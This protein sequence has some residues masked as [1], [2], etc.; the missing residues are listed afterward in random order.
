MTAEEYREHCEERRAA[1]VRVYNLKLKQE[2]REEKVEEVF[3]KPKRN[4]VGPEV[5]L[6]SFYEKRIVA[7]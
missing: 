5:E 1:L 7:H 6:P 2:F 4:Q 3:Y